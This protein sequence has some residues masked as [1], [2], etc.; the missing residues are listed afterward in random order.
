MRVSKNIFIVLFLCLCAGCAG[1]AGVS[2][3]DNGQNGTN[4]AGLDTLTPVPS[5]IYIPV[6]LKTAVIERLIND[7]FNG[8]FHRSDTAV[9][10]GLTNIT[11]SARRNGKVSISARGDELAY[12]LPVKVTIRVSTT[13]SAMGLTHTEHQDAEAGIAISL[14]SKV[15][16]K[17]DWRVTT[18]TKTAGYKWT[19]EPVLKARFITIPI[20]P[21]A[22]FFA[23]RLMEIIGPMLDNSLANSDIVKNSVIAP[24]WEQ[25]YTPISFIL[26]ETQEIIWMRFNPVCLYFSSLDGRGTSIFALIGI[27]AVT[28]ALIGDKP[29]KY[30]PQPLPD[31][32]APPEG[33]DSAFAVNLYAEIPYASA[34]AL[35][36]EKFNG[37]TF[38]SGMHKVTVND[39][40]IIGATA[41]SMLAMK[42]DL[43]GS[44]K[45]IVQITGRAVCNEKE[46]FL[47]LTDI[48]FDLATANR[49][50]KAKNWLLRGIIINKM[51]PLIKFPLSTMLNAEVLTKTLL[52]DYPVQKGIVLNG[53]ID[54]LTVR[55]VETT[56]SAI[57]AAVLAFGTAKMTVAS[58]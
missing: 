22:G 40:E 14:R 56:E 34:T 35:C 16:L 42:L 9:L 31:F 10:G 1:R 54:S 47:T 27:R 30:D 24:L 46:K 6:E 3:D 29:E 8:T 52:T 15:S 43:S 57:R 23:D 41:E 17:N 53:R 13:I 48:K 49:Y 20:K 36:K 44:L 50:Q 2:F 58:E 25:L 32:T 7:R 12:S 37:K 45:G 11:I 38:K 28:E 21:V 18:S 51:K 26:P 4:P 39:I 5:T 33:T 19:S 55:G